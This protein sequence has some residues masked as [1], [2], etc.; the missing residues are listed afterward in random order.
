VFVTNPAILKRASRITGNAL[1][2]AQSDR[3]VIE[4]SM[5]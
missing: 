1:L 3:H 4:T 5:R 2:V